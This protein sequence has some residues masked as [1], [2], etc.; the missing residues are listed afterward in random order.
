MN[1][2]LDIQEVQDALHACR[3]ATKNLHTR[4]P[5]GLPLLVALALEL[6]LSTTAQN[7]KVIIEMAE[8]TQVDNAIQTL[9]I[10]GYDVVA[11]QR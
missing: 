5:N 9:T 2:N 7:L 1:F 11:P 10:A 4:Y 6:D 8:K 3:V